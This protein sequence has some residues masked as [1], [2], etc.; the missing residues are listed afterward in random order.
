MQYID[1]N[2]LAA[3]LD[4]TL[5]KKER[6]NVE[7]AIE[8][9]DELKAIVDEWILMLSDMSNA[10]YRE[11]DRDLRKEACERIHDVMCTIK[12]PDDEVQVAASASPHGFNYRKILVAASVLAFVSMAIIWMF[13]GSWN[14]PSSSDVP[15]GMDFEECQSPS[16][17]DTTVNDTCMQYSIH[18]EWNE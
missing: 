4:G 12:Q 17:V 7:E 2:K 15:M 5:S 18:S 1:S 10:E 14:S 16:V 13:N 9:S 8:H 3:Y 11:D 6:E